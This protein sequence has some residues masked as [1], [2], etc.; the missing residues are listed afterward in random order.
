MPGIFKSK[1]AFAIVIALLFIGLFVL[2]S[3]L[4]TTRLGKEIWNLGHLGA[5][6]TVWL[7]LCNLFKVFKPDSLKRIIVIITVTLLV[8]VAI[9]VIQYYIGRSASRKD[10]GLNL[11][12]TFLALIVVI[13]ANKYFNVRRYILYVVFILSTGVLVWKSSTVIFDEIQR[14]L[15]FPV[16]ADFSKPY[17]LGR[18]SYSSARLEIIETDIGQVL[19]VTLLP[20]RQYQSIGFQTAGQDWTKYQEL[21]IV[22]NNNSKS[23][24]PL[25]LRIHDTKH[26]K[27][28]EDRYNK[29]R[30]IP[31]GLST[32]TVKLQD[33]HYAPRNRNMRLDEIQ[34]IM[35]FTANIKQETQFQIKKIYLR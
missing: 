6:F 28:Y 32:I 35:L 31:P 24:L 18:W 2:K 7:F 5:F 8:S 3:D 30:E 26:N 29:S 12:G 15:L 13:H 20:I 16:L 1:I 11:A 4:V 14:R 22:I 10:V 23:E 33:L 17:E 9:E 34:E 25:T 27:N 19:N 21:L